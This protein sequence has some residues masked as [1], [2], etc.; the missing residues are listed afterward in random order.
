MV[1]HHSLWGNWKDPFMAAWSKPCQGKQREPVTHL[2]GP[3]SSPGILLLGKQEIW[4][5]LGS[6]ESKWQQHLRVKMRHGKCRL[7]EI[8]R[9]FLIWAKFNLELMMGSDINGG[10]WDLQLFYSTNFSLERP[11]SSNSSRTQEVSQPS[12]AC[13]FLVLSSASPFICYMQNAVYCCDDQDSAYV[14][15]HTGKEVGWAD[16]KRNGL[17]HFPLPWGI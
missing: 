12:L 16:N 2:V 1:K 15:Q 9:D 7:S 14:T 8:Y 11:S 10:N 13:S 5:V 3:M 6:A 17:P 4:P